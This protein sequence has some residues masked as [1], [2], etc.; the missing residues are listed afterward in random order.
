IIYPPAAQPAG[1]TA[2]LA[3]RPR[4]T[5]AP[6]AAGAFGAGLS[7]RCVE[8]PW[9]QAWLEGHARILDVGFALSDIGWLR[10]L[11]DREAEITAVDI[12]SPGR[13]ANRYPDDLRD[14]ALAVPVILGDV[15]TAP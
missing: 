6:P 10:R 15:R 11:L 8:G 2:N 1:M 14:R 3:L 13:V 5:P 7:E 4:W 12:V 9:A